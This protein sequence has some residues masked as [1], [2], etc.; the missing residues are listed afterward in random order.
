MDHLRQMRQ[1]RGTVSLGGKS[2]CAM[3]FSGVVP[4]LKL[5][6]HLCYKLFL[7][8]TTKEKLPYFHE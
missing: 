1:P 8:H 4:G 2:L 3:I 6:Q 5:V 7:W